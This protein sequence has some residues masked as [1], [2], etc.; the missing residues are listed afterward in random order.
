MAVG[1]SPPAQA[2]VCDMLT[3]A[4]K[5]AV[6]ILHPGVT[7]GEVDRAVHVPGV[8]GPTVTD[9]IYQ[10]GGVAKSWPISR[11]SCSGCSMVTAA[12]I[13]RVLG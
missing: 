12:T 5:R 7:A 11:G 13:R 3:A 8:G 9:V 10:A 4:Q 2:A 1:D 6:A